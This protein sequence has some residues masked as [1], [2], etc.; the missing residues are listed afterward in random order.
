MLVDTGCRYVILGHSERRHVFGETDEVI[1]RKVAA[2]I[3]GG[4]EVILCVG[5]LLAEREG[6]K[7]GTVLDRHMAGGLSQIKEEDLDHVTVAV[8]TGVGHRHGENG[9]PRPGRRGPSP[10]SQVA[11]NSLQFPAQRGSANSVRGKRQGRQ[12]AGVDVAGRCRRE[13][14]SAGPAS[15]RILSWRLSK[16]PPK[17]RGVRRPVPH[18]G[19]ERG[20]CHND[21]FLDRY[22]SILFAIASIFLIFIVLLQRGRGGGL[23]RRLRATGG[24]STFGTKAGDIFTRITI[25][26]AVIWVCG[27]RNR[28]CHAGREPGPV[29][30]ARHGR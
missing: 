16:Q 28:L 18:P 3:A 12:R 2:A 20:R 7:T 15:R 13:R 23:R 27:G 8:R 30:A 17:F 14:L 26:V 4:L 11:G 1:G 29:Q 22:F 19:I 9:Q 21:S 5:E 25:G 6:D 10:P 24:Q